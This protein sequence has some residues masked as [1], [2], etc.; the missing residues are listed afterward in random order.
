MSK[1]RKISLIL[2]F[3]VLISSIIGSIFYF[4]AR[5]NTKAPLAD[6]EIKS[7]YNIGDEITLTSGKLT[8]GQEEFSVF[9][10]IY[11]PDGTAYVKEKAIL[12]QIGKYTIEYGMIKDGEY[13]FNRKEFFVYNHLLSNSSTYAPFKYQ[14][15]FGYEG[16]STKIS[17]VRF[18]LL[19]GEKLTYN[20]IIDLNRYD[21]NETLVKIEAIPEVPGLQDAGQLFFTLTDVYDKNNTVTLRMKQ[22]PGSEDKEVSYSHATHGNNVYMGMYEERPQSHA[23]YGVGFDNGFRGMSDGSDSRSKTAHIDV[24]FDYSEKAFYINNSRRNGLLL[25]ADLDDHFGDNAWGGFTTGEAWLSIYA[26]TYRTNDVSA[27]FKG[28]ILEID[29]Q[30]LSNGLSEDGTVPSVPVTYTNKPVIDFK[31]YQSVKNIPNA[32]VGYSYKLFDVSHLSIYGAERLYTN[33][34]Y[35]YNTSSSYELPIVNGY[36]TPDKQ[37]VY[38]IIYSAQDRF[39]NISTANLDVYA[40][41]NSPKAI[42]VEVPNHDAYKTGFVGQEFILQDRNEVITSGNLGFVYVSIMANHFAENATES[43][44][45]VEITGDSFVP[46]LSGKW[47]IIYT[48]KDYAGRVGTF[49]YDA[50]VGIDEK[51]VFEQAKDMPKYFIVGAKNPIPTLTYIDYNVGTDS[52][53][54]GTTYVKKDDS[55]VADVTEGYFTPS[56][57]GIYEVVYEQKSSK[58]VSATKAYS[59]RAIDVKFNKKGEFNVEKYFYS[60]NGDIVGTSSN[61]VADGGGV[62]LT[63][64]E[65][66]EFDF[67][68]PVGTT[69]FEFKFKL[70]DSI[71]RAS[72][73][74][75]YLS[76]VNNSNQVLKFTFKPAS[77][78]TK[79]ILNDTKES[80][81]ENYNFKGG[82]FIVSMKAGLLSIANVSIKIDNFVNGDAFNGFDS[83]IANMKFKINCDSTIEGNTQITIKELNLQKFYNLAD[84]LDLISPM[85]IS[86]QSIPGTTTINTTVTLSASKAV[87]ILDPY[88]TSSMTVKGPNNQPIQDINGTVLENVELGKDYVIQLSEIGSYKIYYKYQDTS[89]KGEKGVKVSK[90]ITVISREKPVIEITK[91]DLEGKV[92]KEFKIG[93]AT[94]KGL[95]S[96]ITL[97]VY[98]LGPVGN[99]KRVDTAGMVYVPETAGNYEVRYVAI[100]EWGNMTY[101][102]YTVKIS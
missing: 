75:V 15:D 37:G 19:S 52:K 55:K 61:S 85:I 96:K 65:N 71:N 43:D 101:S 34:Y 17:G 31:E 24:R 59:V 50:N 88:V 83:L 60:E 13:Y 78:G 102:S 26:D 28:M 94:C 67:I 20:K 25:V 32:M 86:N 69:A 44:L 47:Q 74:D 82:D 41:P 22:S 84:T 77:N 93:S 64:K 62:N 49:S 46:N 99:M 18:D 1:N 4:S 6:V 3:I 35:G 66:G 2:C 12:D 33:V 79:L 89:G 48:A 11:Y 70:S 68:R 40:L 54:V 14:K 87:D 51:V 95:S 39:G 23:N 92:N 30:D 76:D 90:S 98:V 81:I 29:N 58:D 42:Y 73:L 7:Q 57:E 56:E 80:L 45:S 10:K 100:D 97:K 63:V 38:T 91:G 9:P 53:T 8:I 21:K 36:F 72:S 27:I 5:A 16:Q